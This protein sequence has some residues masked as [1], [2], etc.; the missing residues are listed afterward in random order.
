MCTTY[1]VD[2]LGASNIANALDMCRVLTHLPQHNTRSTVK[3][4]QYKYN[5]TAQVSQHSTH[6]TPTTAHHT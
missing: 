3:H 4:P 6:D 5:N 1:H 2:F